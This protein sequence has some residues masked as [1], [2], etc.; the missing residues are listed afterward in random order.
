MYSDWSLNV[1]DLN[2]LTFKYWLCTERAEFD[3]GF[4]VDWEDFERVELDFLTWFDFGG[5][6][7]S[8]SNFRM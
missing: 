5:D 3:F 7:A 4:K 6:W 8:W 1:F 2:R